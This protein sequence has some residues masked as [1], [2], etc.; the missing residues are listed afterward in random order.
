MHDT[1][2]RAEVEPMAENPPERVTLTGLY[3]VVIYEGD[4]FVRSDKE[5]ISYR[6]A[7]RLAMALNGKLNVARRSKNAGQ[8]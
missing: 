8:T 2:Y 1:M 6:E 7:R 3:K 5:R 4:R